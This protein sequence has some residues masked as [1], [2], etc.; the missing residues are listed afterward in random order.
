MPTLWTAVPAAAIR[1]PAL[2]NTTFG[3]TDGAN[4]AV[5]SSFIGRK[6]L[7]QWND[8]PFSALMLL[9]YYLGALSERRCRWNTCR[10]VWKHHVW[11]QGTS[12][13]KMRNYPRVVRE[14][15]TWCWNA[16]NVMSPRCPTQNGDDNL[17]SLNLKITFA[18]KSTYFYAKSQ[19][20]LL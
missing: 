10:D 6:G 20:F 5:L 7:C 14:L 4:K 13:V 15:S 18:F 17:I 19:I 11:S 16:R 8:K 9:Y 3:N 12:H 1:R 2:R